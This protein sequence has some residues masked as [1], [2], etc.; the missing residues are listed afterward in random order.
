MRRDIIILLLI[1]WKRTA[2]VVTQHT[3]SLVRGIISRTGLNSRLVP[4]A[5]LHIFLG[6]Y[7]HTVGVHYTTLYYCKSR[8]L[9]K[10]I[11]ENL[12]GCYSYLLHSYT[13]YL[14]CS[15]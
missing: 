3:S 9:G 5:L 10:I 13:P 11:C 4:F 15:I 1:C 6:S 7:R 2:A 8:L 14:F 12:S